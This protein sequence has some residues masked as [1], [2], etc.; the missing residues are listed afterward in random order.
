MLK[1]ATNP[2]FAAR[3]NWSVITRPQLQRVLTSESVEKEYALRDLIDWVLLEQMAIRDGIDV[4]EQARSYMA[5]NVA[6]AKD[7]NRT[8]AL[9]LNEREQ[10]EE[11]DLL[12]QA[13]VNRITSS[14]PVS[15]SALESFYEGHR[16]D[17]KT[18]ENDQVALILIAPEGIPAGLNLM[19]YG[20]QKEVLEARQRAVEARKLVINGVK[21]EDV[22]RRFPNVI[23]ADDSDKRS[24][25]SAM[26][27]TPVGAVSEVIQTP[28]GFAVFEVIQRNPAHLSSFVEAEAEV[29]SIVTRQSVR[30]YLDSMRLYSFLEVRD[31]LVDETYLDMSMSFDPKQGLAFSI[32][33]LGVALGGVFVIE[34]VLRMQ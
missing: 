7:D 12:V 20:Q 23:S 27:A 13:E 25:M 11:D 1:D 8:A 21:F 34:L 24:I 28:H 26:A 29:E 33:L 9:D 4:H 10:I 16:A 30:E 3:V 6:N 32:V 15:R 18:S 19:H 5:S 14:F 22:A 17:F 31:G 2:E